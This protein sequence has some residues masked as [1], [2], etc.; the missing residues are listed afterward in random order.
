MGT[1]ISMHTLYSEHSTLE[2]QITTSTLHRE[3]CS[4]PRLATHTRGLMKAQLSYTALLVLVYSTTTIIFV[5]AN[6]LQRSRAV[7]KQTSALAL[8]DDIDLAVRN[9]GQ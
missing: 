9:Y 7:A 5:M 8:V 4:T 2:A 3:S 6:S 1:A